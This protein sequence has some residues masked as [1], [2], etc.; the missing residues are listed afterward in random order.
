MKKT[1]LA[2][3]ASVLALTLTACGGD[4]SDQAAVDAGYGACQDEFL[5]S[6]GPGALMI[7]DELE[8][9]L[10]R[11]GESGVMAGPVELSGPLPDPGW[12]HCEAAISDGVAEVTKYK[13]SLM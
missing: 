3:T 8:F 10:Y 1:I 7:T 6:A 11:D 9:Q 12:M 4:S 5:R 2:L 13:I